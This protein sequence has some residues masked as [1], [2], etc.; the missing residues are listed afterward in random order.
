MPLIHC[1]IEQRLLTADVVKLEDGSI[2]KTVEPAHEA[3]LRQ[4]N[5][6]YNWLDDE[7][8]SLITLEHVERAA[9]DWYRNRRESAGPASADSTTD[10]EQVWLVH[11]DARLRQ[12]ET[13]LNKTA[14]KQVAGSVALKYI[15]ACRAAEDAAEAAEKLRIEQE[16]QQIA[17]NRKLQRRGFVLLGAA[18]AAVLLG[19]AGVITL[20]KGLNQR[21]SNTLTAM[22]RQA[23]A[24]GFSDRAVRYALASMAGRNRWLVGFD[25][26]SAEDALNIERQAS[27]SKGALRGHRR[28]VRVAQFSPDGARI[29]TG[30][31]DG[32]ARIWDARTGTL[33]HELNA[34]VDKMQSASF[35]ADGSRIVTA[36]FD[37][38]AY[39]WNA[40]TGEKS[41]SLRHVGMEGKI[42][43]VWK[44]AFSPDGKL[45]VTGASDNLVRVW[46][47]E[48]GL[49][50][51]AFS[52]HE[53]TA[54]CS[55]GVV[56]SSTVLKGARHANEVRDVSFSR[57]GKRILSTSLDGDVAVWDVQS[58]DLVRRIEFQQHA[59]ERERPLR[60][61]QS[62][63]LRKAVIVEFIG[64]GNE[65]RALFAIDVG[66]R[67]EHPIGEVERGSAL[68]ALVDF[69]CN[70]VRKER[71]RRKQQTRNVAHSIFEHCVPEALRR[72]CMHRLVPSRTR[73]ETKSFASERSEQ[74][75]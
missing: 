35:S 21:T 68:V 62:Q 34:G 14:F 37:G 63:D 25:A 66:P 24:D 43:Q 29:L 74:T 18:T 1:L 64:K 10:D 22:A 11:R 41:Q 17:R 42:G 47:V 38:N 65:L 32:T 33:L 48:D 69:F 31:Y 3:L 40:E 4:W 7:R 39:I 6:L 50:L 27:G 54:N 20:I 2:E 36:S 75:F 23:Y 19:G 57:D 52:H 12:A 71:A 56:P 9:A 30:S 51:P 44:A 26:K 59:I 70:R 53:Y 49:Q 15:A 72:S 55:R 58:G 13:V 73:R 46:Q 60:I 45:V 8:E 61:V 5:D 67:L 28:S 16:K